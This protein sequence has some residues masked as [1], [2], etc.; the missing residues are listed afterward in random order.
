[1]PAAVSLVSIQWMHQTAI[2][3]LQRAECALVRC[4]LQALFKLAVVSECCILDLAIRSFSTCADKDR[5]ERCT[6]V[7]AQERQQ[8]C[9]LAA[10]TAAQLIHF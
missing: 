4:R 2:E 5:V 10:A 6:T 8:A 9:R 1:M 3:A 7:A